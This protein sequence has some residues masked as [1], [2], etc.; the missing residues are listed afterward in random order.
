MNVNILIVNL[1]IGLVIPAIVQLLSKWNAY[2]AVKSIINLLLSAI[3]GVLS[4]LLTASTVE[5]KIVLLSILQVFVTSLALHYGL[6]KQ[7]GVTGSTGVIAQAVPAGIG[8]SAA[9]AAPVVSTSGGSPVLPSTTGPT[10]PA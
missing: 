4:P 10:T 8:P 3:G 6:Y 1:I 7:I 2:P 5:W 9:S